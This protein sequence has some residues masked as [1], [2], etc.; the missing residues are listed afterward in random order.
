V[1]DMTAVAI[2]LILFPFAF[3]AWSLVVNKRP[4]PPRGKK[5]GGEYTNYEPP[6]ELNIS[7]TEFPEGTADGD[8]GNPR[9]R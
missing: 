6:V 3:A 7:G 8:S 4:Y 5:L 2:F 9:S 1:E